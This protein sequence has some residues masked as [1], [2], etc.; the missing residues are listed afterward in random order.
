M[1]STFEESSFELGL[2]SKAAYDVDGDMLGCVR[3]PSNDF[4]NI[5]KVGRALGIITVTF[6]TIT[7]VIIGIALFFKPKLTPVLWSLIRL[8]PVCGTLS[9]IFTFMILG[10]GQ[11]DEEGC[12]LSGAGAAAVINVFVLSTLSVM[13]NLVPPPTKPW[14]VY[15]SHDVFTANRETVVRD[16]EGY[17]EF[18]PI[19]EAARL[20]PHN[21]SQTTAIDMLGME[22]IDFKDGEL[23][24]PSVSDESVHTNTSIHESLASSAELRQ[25]KGFQLISFTMIFLAWVISLVGVRRCTFLLIGPIGGGQSDYSGIGLYSRAAYNGDDMIGCLAFPDSASDF[26][27]SFQTARVFGAFTAVLMTAVLLLSLVQLFTHVGS[28]KAWYI[29]RALLPSAVICQLLVFLAYRTD[30]CTSSPEFVECIPG[31]AGIMVIINVL[32]MVGLSIFTLLMPPPSTPIFAA[33]RVHKNEVHEGISTTSS[34]A[35]ASG[36]A[37]LTAGN[38]KA[39]SLFTLQ[40]EVFSGEDT[41]LDSQEDYEQREDIVKITPL[42]KTVGEPEEMITISME[43]THDQKRTIKTITHPDG[44]QTVTTTIEELSEGSDFDDDQPQRDAD[45]RPNLLPLAKDYLESVPESE[46]EQ[47]STPQSRMD[48]RPDSPDSLMIGVE[49]QP[50]AIQSVRDMVRNFEASKK[51][52]ASPTNNHG[53]LNAMD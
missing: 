1:A 52:E 19:N 27:T 47:S 35:V 2:F 10:S 45:E 44:S 46:D 6:S 21:V 18:V 14:F 30:M 38:F 13:T 29:T 28:E 4:D 42:A 51:K 33:Y 22:D 16:D 20:Q 48:S 23:P 15:W 41:D 12:N 36:E 53:V 11:C 25:R 37:R 8:L 26:D 24:A 34:L 49:D 9:Q 43:F 17:G 7:F 40:E 39:A 31:G 3:Y 50:N 32:I 5:F